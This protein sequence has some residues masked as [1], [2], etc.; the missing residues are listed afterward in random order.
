MSNSD[1]EAQLET[2]I[3]TNSLL[4]EVMCTHDRSPFA[5]TIVQTETP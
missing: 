2:P 5:D 4:L 1:A 3:N